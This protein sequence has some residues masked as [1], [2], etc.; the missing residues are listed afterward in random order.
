MLLKIYDHEKI[1]TISISIIFLSCHQKE[2]TRTTPEQLK[3]FME[4][5]QESLHDELDNINFATR[6]T[7]E[8]IKQGM[9]VDNALKYQKHLIDSLNS[10]LLKEK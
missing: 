4:R 6:M 1:I 5:S 8:K 7:Q 9:S 2:D 10:K 3:L